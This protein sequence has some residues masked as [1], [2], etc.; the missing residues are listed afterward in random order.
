MTRLAAA[1]HGEIAATTVEAYRRA[2]ASAY[3]DMLAAD[4]MRTD[5]AGAGSNLW[6]ANAGQISQLLCTWNAFALQTLGDAFID[7]D[8]QTNPR[9]IGYL[10]PVTAEQAAAFLGE[11][12]SWSARARRARADGSYDVS[13]EITLPARLPGWSQVEPCPRA[14]LAAMLAAAR[15]MRDRTEAAQADFTRAGIPA[16]AER[17]AARLAGMIADA[18]AVV[19][20]GE[21]LWSPDATGDVHERAES[22]LQRGIAAYYSLGQFL[23]M[24]ALLDRPETEATTA[25]GPRLPLPGHAGFDPWC[26]TD[27]ASRVTWQRDAA[28]R[29]AIDSLW[30]YD[31]DPAGTLTVQS[32]I[33]AAVGAGS[34]T[35]GLTADGHPIG[36]Y[37]CCPWSAIY[38]VR[39]PVT[40]GGMRLRPMQ[41]FTFDVSAEEIAE[42]GEFKRELLLGPFHPTTDVDYCDPSAGGHDD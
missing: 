27:P 8:Y 41:Q 4:Q 20:Y 40:I 38:L 31:P 26:L 11:V 19:S 18:D 2:G 33:D 28:A 23:A 36:S 35:A 3:E 25:A 6:S 10:P 1:L 37:Y 15:A 16:G 13:A 39:K 17:V 34:V 12:E 14:H 5:M 30:R 42:G 7:A 9:T 29:R 22:S 21:S 24:P 32:Q